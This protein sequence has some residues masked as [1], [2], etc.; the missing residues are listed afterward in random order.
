[1]DSRRYLIEE[2]PRGLPGGSVI[3]GWNGVGAP[4]ERIGDERLDDALAAAALFALDSYWHDKPVSV[5]LGDTV[6]ITAISSSGVFLRL[7]PDKTKW[8]E[9]FYEYMSARRIAA[10]TGTRFEGYDLSFE[11]QGVGVKMV[12]SLTKNQTNKIKG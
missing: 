11:N 6:K 10:A 8:R 2:A 1:M 9:K 7:G 4:G 12:G 5:D 3:T